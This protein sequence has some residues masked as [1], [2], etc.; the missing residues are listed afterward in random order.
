MT[1]ELKNKIINYYEEH[2]DCYPSEVADALNADLKEVRDIIK[3]L[4]QEE[5]LVPL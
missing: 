1:E 5:I 2:L 3:E 4:V